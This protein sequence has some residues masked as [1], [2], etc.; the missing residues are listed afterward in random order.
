MII[1]AANQKLSKTEFNNYDDW[2][3]YP[4]SDYCCNHCKQIISINFS[5]LEKH[6][7]S[8][9]SNL[10]ESDSKAFDLFFL[11]TGATPANSFLDFYCPGCKRP[12]RVYYISW[13]GGRHGEFGYSI[14]YVVE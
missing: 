12:V 9:F 8:T 10:S 3:S 5:N 4:T 7:S 2:Q 11:E 14:K 6:A 13:A 1:H